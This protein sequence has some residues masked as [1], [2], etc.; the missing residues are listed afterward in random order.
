MILLTLNILCMIAMNISFYVYDNYGLGFT[1]LG[2]QL[3]CLIMQLITR[4]EV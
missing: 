4:G 2:F 1:F 3:V